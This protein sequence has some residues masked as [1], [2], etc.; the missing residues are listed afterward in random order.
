M[1][2]FIRPPVHIELHFAHPVSLAC[3][4]LQLDLGEGSEARVEVSATS[5]QPRWTAPLGDDE[6]RHC[7][8][9]AI[10]SDGASLQF[11][12][13][14]IFRGLSDRLRQSTM[15]PGSH[16]GSPSSLV[17]SEHG[18]KSWS[19]L[20]RVSALRLSI[21]RL[22][23][24]RPVAIRLLEV[25]ACLAPG[26]SD[27]QRQTAMAAVASAV[28]G[29][30][31]SVNS[32]VAVFGSS[33]ELS[34]RTVPTASNPTATYQCR[35]PQSL[36][37]STSTVSHIGPPLLSSG[38]ETVPP[39]SLGALGSVGRT[40]EGSQERQRKEEGHGEIE[41]VRRLFGRQAGR[42]SQAGPGPTTMKPHGQTLPRGTCESLL[43]KEAVTSSGLTSFDVQEAHS[44]DRSSREA[45]LPP[46]S[47]G[48]LGKSPRG[49]LPPPTDVQAPLGFFDE[50]TC[51][52]MQIPMLL[53]SAHYVDRST[54][55]RLRHMD[56]T[57]GR[58]P[59]DPF[60]G[61]LG[62]L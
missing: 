43:V 44:R 62:V 37:G 4:V 8:G 31:V 36:K 9:V 28:Q 61:A 12:C 59:L 6:F 46:V 33:G 29:P 55:D 20:L 34:G 39:R 10:R 21:T 25:W 23:G 47:H 16:L 30:S 45:V 48:A 7:G 3:I 22:T 54:L 5:S 18:L 17:H 58:A 41:E 57:Y 2:H 19:G 56:L 52:M 24:V 32:H 49:E 51:E 60:T 35:Q 50:L 13:N 40:A 27:E 42:R 15:I 53:P 26:C 38:G 11:L 14:R 1:E